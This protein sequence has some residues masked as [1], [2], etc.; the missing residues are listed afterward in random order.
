M[1]KEH[2]PNIQLEDALYENIAGGG[3]EMVFVTNPWG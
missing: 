3:F 1:G 2:M